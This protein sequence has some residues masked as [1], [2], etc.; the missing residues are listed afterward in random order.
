MENQQLI[1]LRQKFKTYLPLIIITI[2]SIIMS[3][4]LAKDSQEIV[5]RFMGF[6]LII[7]SLFKWINYFGFIEA[8]KQYDIVS[9]FFKPYP[10]LYPLIELLL[11]LFYINMQLLILCNIV[12]IIVMAFLTIS[13][14]KAI[15]QKRSISCACLGTTIDLPLTVVSLFEA[16]LMLFMAAI[17]L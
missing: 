2:F 8:F 9:K 10:Y 17:M 16:V 5:Y 7:F 1:K 3:L 4:V 14:G 6:F 13:I 15:A 11:G 12:T